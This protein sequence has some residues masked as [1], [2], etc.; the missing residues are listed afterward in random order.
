MHD[1]DGYIRETVIVLESHIDHLSGEEIGCAIGRLMESG[2]LD[3][4]W[5]PGVMKKNRPGGAFR[6]VCRPEDEETVLA[7]FFRHTHTLGIRRQPVE[8]VILPRGE[9][10]AECGGSR[11]RTKEYVLEGEE[12][13]RVEHDELACL[14]KKRGTGVPALRFQKKGRE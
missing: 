6:V 3:A 7:A 13:A 2:A 11:L 4:I 9:G 5:L 1:K 8:R 14:A 10:E 12:Y